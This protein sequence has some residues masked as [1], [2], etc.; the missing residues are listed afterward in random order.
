M[1]KVGGHIPGILFGFLILV[2]GV[3]AETLV[4]NQTA[5]C[6][7]GASYHPNITSAEAAAA[8]SDTITVC[9]GTYTENIDVDVSVNIRSYSQNAS[10]TIV[11]VSA[12][13][14]HVFN[15]SN[16]NGV[17][18]SGFTVTGATG[19]A[20]AGIYLVGADYCNISNNNAS[21]NY[22]GIYLT[23]S[24]NYNT[25]SNNTANSNNKYGIYLDSSNGSNIINNT[26]SDGAE[27]IYFEYSHHTTILNNTITF[28][29]EGIESYDSD[30]ITAKGNNVSYNRDDGIF[31]TD[32]D[33]VIISD[34]IVN[35]NYDGQGDG[36]GIYVSGWDAIIPNITIANNTVNSN[37][38]YGIYL[39]W[40]TNSTIANNT[41]NS[42]KFGITLDSSTNVNITENTANSNELDGIYLYW[43]SDNNTINNNIANSNGDFGFYIYKSRYNLLANNTANSNDR[44][45][46]D[47]WNNVEYNTLTNN[48][49]SLNKYGFE[50]G[51][52]YITLSENNAS[53]NLAYGILLRDGFN[54]IT[55]NTIS[56]NPYGIG[57]DWSGNDQNN[58][59]DNYISENF[60]GI[61][62]GGSDNNR[63][64]NNTLFDNLYYGIALW[65]T[66]TN[67]DIQNNTAK[68]NYFGVYIVDSNNNNVTNNVLYP[69]Y[70]SGFTKRNSYNITESNNTG[71]GLNYSQ[72][73]RGVHVITPSQ[74]IQS[75]PTGTYAEYAIIIA[76]MGN[77]PDAYDITL[78]KPDG[79]TTL[80]DVETP[81][82]PGE[83]TINI[84][85][86]SYTGLKVR[87]NTIGAYHVS[88]TVT[89]QN[90]PTVL[91]TVEV[92]TIVH[93]D[94]HSDSAIINST[95]SDST[96][97]YSSI[98]NSTVNTS[99]VS[100]SIIDGSISTNSNI[101][102][103]E[104]YNSTVVNSELSNVKL[105]NSPVIDGIITNG[106]IKKAGVLYNITRNVTISELISGTDTEDSTLFG[107]TEVNK[108]LNFTSPGANISFSIATAS[109]YI[110]GSLTA[111]RSAHEPA[112]T[113]NMSH[114]VG[115]YSWIEPSTNLEEG[116]ENVLM[117][118]Y[119]NESDLLPGIAEE[120]LRFQFF[121]TTTG[122]WEYLNKTFTDDFTTSSAW[123]NKSGNWSLSGNR[124]NASSNGT[125]ISL[126]NETLTPSKT[127]VQVMVNFTNATNS[128]SLVIF[129]YTSASSF[130]Y[131]GIWDYIANNTYKQVFGYY[132]G[133]WNHQ[134]ESNVEINDTE[135]YLLEVFI[136]GVNSTGGKLGLGVYNATATFSNYTVYHPQSGVNTVENYVWGL[137][138]H[139]S[140]YG[141][142]GAVYGVDGS[143][144]GVAGPVTTPSTVTPS[145]GGGPSPAKDVAETATVEDGK[146]KVT[147]TKIS[148]EKTGV[149]TIPETAEIPLKEIAIKV[150]N[151][152]INTKIE[153]Y[154]LAEKPG[155]ISE[156]I[157]GITH[158][159]IQIDE[160]N[161]E[162]ADIDTVTIKFKVPLSWI[163][164]NDIDK[165]KVVLNR[166]AD[167]RW[168]A[169]TTTEETDDGKFVH[170][171]ASSPGLSVFAIS[172]E[173]VEPAPISAPTTTAAPVTPPPT[174]APPAVSHK[175]ASPKEEDKG[176]CGPSAILL[177]MMLPLAAKRIRKK[178]K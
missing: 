112:G 23:S 12:S 168:N 69:N 32:S 119:Y 151:T 111:Q 49:V 144:Y 152:I 89:S 41:A 87:S 19:S 82:D 170:Y 64:Y 92:L 91:D 138:P 5:S 131:S 137:A 65:K 58:F 6:T 68:N 60:H 63:I 103:S 77:V 96:F 57:T 18:I 107:M 159:Y 79:G 146:A 108:S 21:N 104:I 39:S 51:G 13:T 67:N 47:L 29:F 125:A 26:I 153:V 70:Y 74:K 80:T 175:V 99:T 53:S 100:Y 27:G 14:D 86:G 128:T 33:N 40:S 124:Y 81:T 71:G 90:D 130:W 142:N 28:T 3:S 45:G 95:V 84:K 43:G 121:N 25:I 141:I 120:D 133:T 102:Y 148:A 54:T 73:V 42:N 85:S 78:S 93:N 88:V 173:V 147:L 2:G 11:S 24:S 157:T 1:G 126:I 66:S 134:N 52:N 34:N 169:L 172:G 59:S 158:S 109:D 156:D 127:Y 132:N 97:Y 162:A 31:L 16:V 8:D 160:T 20:K 123:T 154:E 105:W 61:Y 115:G 163:K 118:I 114:N 48:T 98:E 10:D 110:G 36:N 83:I 122:Q 56:N 145:T 72:N 7:T 143:V 149:I 165:A 15:V 136:T 76:N 177:F 161:I 116:M 35:S 113:S 135:N 44:A 101:S 46:F 22:N 171:S 50:L 174:T 9:P 62:L 155:S 30:Y 166:Y 176:I 167:G 4:V 37:G 164:E 129:N 17:N 75:V 140:V 106:T 150:K 55:G 117:K 178:G 94:T 38:D 139:F